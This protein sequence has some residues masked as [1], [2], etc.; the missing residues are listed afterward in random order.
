MVTPALTSP[1]P[2]SPPAPR[3]QSARRPGGDSA[4]AGFFHALVRRCPVDG[5]ELSPDPADAA[6]NLL[7]VYLAL[8]AAREP[9]PG[10]GE[11]RGGFST[12]AQAARSWQLSLSEWASLPLGRRRA[13]SASNGGQ[14]DSSARRRSGRYR[15][16]GLRVGAAASHVLVYDRA[17]KMVVEERIAPVLMLAMR[18]LYQSRAGRLALRQGLA[19]RLT[20]MSAREGRYRDSAESAKDIAPFVESFRG[21]IDVAE[22][23]RPLS[24]YGTFNEFFYRRLRPGARPVAAPA[25]GDVLV[26]AADC[27]LMAFEEATEAARFWVKG[28]NFSVAG[29]LADTDP[30]RPLAARFDGGALAIFRLAPQDY[31][32]WHTP[33][34]GRVVSIADVPGGLLTVNPV[35]VN[36]PLH[37]V[38]TENKR[39]VALLE[40]PGLG[41]VAVVAVGATLVGSIVWTVAVGDELDKGGEMGHFAFGG[42]TVV[43]LFEPGAAAWDADLLANSRRSLETLVRVGERV[44]ARGGSAAAGVA[45]VAGVAGEAAAAAAAAADVAGVVALE[46]RPFE[47]RMLSGESSGALASV[48][49]APEAAAAESGES[50]GE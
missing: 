31:H 12:A 7:Y 27:R 18:K 16:G 1:L 44:G 20:A 37:D 28:R 40:S 5:A 14:S 6:A 49:E 39:S 8:A 36:S 11:L 43:A 19:S 22:A 2:P 3:A 48:L 50:G 46:E 21:E 42:S 38:F 26:S 33:V 29:L 15:A 47:A 13:S 25:D 17:R 24:E 32:R 9:P 23:E 35:A 4:D 45:G 41:L 10:E 30:E 34:A